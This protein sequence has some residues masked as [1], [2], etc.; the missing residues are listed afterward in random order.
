MTVCNGGKSTERVFLRATHALGIDFIDILA[1][2]TFVLGMFS[3]CMHA[4]PAINGADK[5]P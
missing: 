3:W 1:A 5:Q 2:L 4:P